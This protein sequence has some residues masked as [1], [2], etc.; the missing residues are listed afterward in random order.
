MYNPNE[1]FLIPISQLVRSHLNCRAVDENH[2]ALLISQLNNGANLG[3]ITCRPV[4][5]MSGLSNT[6]EICC[7]QH[8]V[9]A[10]KRLG[11]PTIQS[12][13]KTM[14]DSDFLA[15]SISE[16]IHRK[17]MLN[18]EVWD[19]ASNLYQM[20]KSTKDIAV[21]LAVSPQTARDYICCGYFLCDTVKPYLDK[22]CVGKLLCKVAK[23]HQLPVF[24]R[25]R[26]QPK[27]S[28]SAN[29][30]IVDEYISQHP[31]SRQ[32]CGIKDVKITSSQSPT[33][34]QPPLNINTYDLPTVTPSK[35]PDVSVPHTNF[36]QGARVQHT[37]QH[38]RQQLPTPQI[39]TTLHTPQ[40]PT[41]LP[42]QIPTTLPPRVPTTLPPQI[43]TTLPP[44]IPT[45]HPPQIPTTGRMSTTGA[46]LN[47]S[48]PYDKNK[49]ST[50]TIDDKSLVLERDDLVLLSHA[51]KDIPQLWDL[52]KFIGNMLPAV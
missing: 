35:L 4:S 43:P 38:S 16:N 30:A 23:T 20:G 8:R 48:I 5:T 13:I 9:E 15:S 41:T 12:Y 22:K 42:P 17:S 46:V 32:S 11:R 40:I 45:S 39:P 52:N 18:H 28:I 49:G 36:L 26:A 27:S 21:T 50:I 37:L 19:T 34:I 47:P 1:I 6:F 24:D 51:I 33:P 29:S 3:P 44:Q 10:F 31:G 25:I 14:S 7:G 2:V